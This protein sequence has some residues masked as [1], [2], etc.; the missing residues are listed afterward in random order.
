[1]RAES[2]VPALQRL[3]RSHRPQRSDEPTSGIFA[4]FAAS[5]IPALQRLA[6]PGYHSKRQR[7]DDETDEELDIQFEEHD[8]EQRSNFFF[9]I[10]ATALCSTHTQRRERAALA[11]RCM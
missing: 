7:L 3:A 10:I 2:G 4:Q 8:E 6:H 5:G 11:V 9:L 1:M